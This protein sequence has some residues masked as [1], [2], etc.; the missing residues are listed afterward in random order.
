M[1]TSS[2]SY[3]RTNS[4]A[5]ANAAL[6]LSSRSCDGPGRFSSG[7]W[8]IQQRVS[9]TV[10]SSLSQVENFEQRRAGVGRPLR[11]AST[12]DAPVGAQEKHGL[13]VGVEPGLQS[14]R[15]VADDDDVGVVVTSPAQLRHRPRRNESGAQRLPPAK[16]VVAEQRAGVVA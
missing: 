6:I 5:S 7:L 15:A 2:G 14:S 8:D 9:G 10:T 16:G 12:R 13:G 1:T 11:N 4:R 3:A